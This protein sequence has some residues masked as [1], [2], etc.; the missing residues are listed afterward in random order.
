MKIDFNETELA[1]MAA[2]A[3]CDGKEGHRLQNQFI[4]ELKQAMR[5]GMDHCPC[6]MD[7]PH[8]G[9]CVICVQIHRGHGDHLPACMREMVNRKL[10][11]LSALTEHTI[12]DKVAKPDY[13]D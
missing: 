10:E 3:R 7:C 4:D 6:T 12:T 8:H 13:L 11:G 2:F 5:G 1:A 9:K